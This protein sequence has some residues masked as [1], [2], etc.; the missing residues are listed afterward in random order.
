MGGGDVARAL[1]RGELEG[2]GLSDPD[3]AMLRYAVKLTRSPHAVTAEDVERLR[4]HGF[5]DTAIHDIC[6]VASYYNYVN[7]MAD[8]LAVELE[9]RWTDEELTLTR[10]EFAEAV[11]ARRVR[12]A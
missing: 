1:A 4:G 11:R 2:A 7:R 9:D 6:H 10:E 8:G 12:D 3:V 5:D